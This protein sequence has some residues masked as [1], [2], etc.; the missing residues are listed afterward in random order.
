[1][2]EGF[3]LTYHNETKNL[4][5]ITINAHTQHKFSFFLNRLYMAK[6]QHVSQKHVLNLVK[7]TQDCS[8]DQMRHELIFFSFAESFR[9][10]FLHL[11]CLLPKYLALASQHFLPALAEKSCFDFS[12]KCLIGVGKPSKARSLGL[13]THLKGRCLQCLAFLQAVNSH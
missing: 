10:L 9:L 7:I 6:V 11:Y 13:D 5:S 8:L 1:M 2:F 12:L 3:P 4:S